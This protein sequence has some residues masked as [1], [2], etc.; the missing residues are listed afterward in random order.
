[1]DTPTILWHIT[2]NPKINMQ[3]R[4]RYKSKVDICFYCPSKEN[5]L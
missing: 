3:E 2:E 1:M 4:Q 5:N